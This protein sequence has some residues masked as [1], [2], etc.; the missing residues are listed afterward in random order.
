MFDI[1]GWEFLVIIVIAIIV[2]GPKDLPGTIR[3]V[4]SWIR[5]ARELARDF[6][7]GLDDLAREAELDSVRNDI[8][9]GL[10]IDEVR[11][12]GHSIRREIE[13]SVDPGGEIADAFTDDDRL[14]AGA[15]PKEIPP[16]PRR[17]S[18]VSDA[19]AEDRGRPAEDAPAPADDEP[20]PAAKKA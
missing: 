6:Q 18:T 7:S 20:A 13:H 2:I 1:G 15:D 11:D 17:E 4:T 10:G 9:S 16:P 12:A 5:R 14:L 3:T 19:A 8:E